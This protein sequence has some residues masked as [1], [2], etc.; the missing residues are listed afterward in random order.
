MNQSNPCEKGLPTYC[1]S[2]LQAINPNFND[3]QL[4]AI[5]EVVTK[6]V[7]AIKNSASNL[8][9]LTNYVQVLK[10]LC[11]ETLPPSSQSQLQSSLLQFG[12]E[13]EKIL[14]SKNLTLESHLDD[15]LAEEFDQE[16][17]EAT[18]RSIKTAQNLHQQTCNSCQTP[19][20][21]IE[22]NTRPFQK[23]LK[24]CSGC[25]KALYCSTECQRKDWSHHKVECFK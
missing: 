7:E 14:K 25:R 8:S 21:L 20:R 6:Q 2:V 23:L 24:K 17:L 16:I 12:V 19:N 18:K 10:Q 9:E 22:S 3:E 11:N 1:K 5:T 13:K 15:R 4:N